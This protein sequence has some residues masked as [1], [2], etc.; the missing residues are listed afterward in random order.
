MAG[1]ALVLQV[2]HPTVGAGVSEHSV[3]RA[4]PWGRLMR[5]LD[6]FYALV[7]GGP[8]AAAQT[9]RRLRAFHRTIKGVTPD[10]RRYR[11]LDPEAYAWVHATLADAIVR[12]HAR[13][14]DRLEP[15]ER[16]RFWAEWRR[17][18]RLLGIRSG[19]LPGDWPEFEAYV[20]HMI[21]DRLEHTTAVDDVLRI[22]AAP[23]APPLPL[24]V[25]AGW[26]VA[27]IPLGRALVLVT[28]GMLPAPLRER[29]GLRWTRA[30]QLELD[31]IARGLRAMTPLLGATRSVGP[32]YLALRRVASAR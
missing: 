13:V 21:R 4:D 6:A 30:Q 17:V 14:G 7:Y 19:D 28:A 3:F 26:P 32:A 12:G 11:A 23:G 16:E 31:V 1:Y 25:R 22:L 20:E 15:A 24:P 10:G 27:G 18:G 5:T 8:E 29:F 9:G 2:A